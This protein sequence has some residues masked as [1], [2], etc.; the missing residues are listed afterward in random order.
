MLRRNRCKAASA[1]VRCAVYLQTRRPCRLAPLGP[2]RRRA[3]PR[4]AR[5]R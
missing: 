5:R 1:N 3:G 4:A 2:E